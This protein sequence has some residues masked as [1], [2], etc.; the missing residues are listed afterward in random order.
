MLPRPLS[1]TP[2]IRGDQLKKVH[3]TITL[4]NRHITFLVPSQ[5]TIAAAAATLTAAA[6]QYNQSKSGSTQQPKYVPPAYSQNAEFASRAGNVNSNNTPSAEGIRPT[7]PYTARQTKQSTLQSAPNPN[8]SS[9]TYGRVTPAEIHRRANAAIFEGT[10]RI[11]VENQP[12]NTVSASM[13]TFIDPSEVFNPYHYELEKRRREETTETVTQA[14]HSANSSAQPTQHLLHGQNI[15]DQVTKPQ[16]AKPKKPRKPREKKPRQS[17]P[18]SKS[19]VQPPA[20]NQAPTVQTQ[21]SPSVDIANE[22]KSMIE[23]MREWKS[24]DPKLFQSLWDDMKK[25]S[26]AS[27][28]TLVQGQSTDAATSSKAADNPKPSQSSS[29]IQNK[30]V[31]PPSA[32]DIAQTSGPIKFSTPAVGS[33]STQSNQISLD[34]AVSSTSQTKSPAQPGLAQRAANTSAKITKANATPA[35]P[36]PPTPSVSSQNV[37]SQPLPPLS[38]RGGTIWPEDK[39]KALAEAA[40]TALNTDPANNGK[41]ITPNDIRQII[42]ENPSY[43]EL[44]RRL[45]NKGLVFQRSGFARHLLSS[46]PDLTSASSPQQGAP[47]ITSAPISLQSQSPVT[48]VMAREAS[49]P[50]KESP[51]IPSQTQRIAKSSKAS[52]SQKTGK[53]STVPEPPPGSKAAMARKRNFSEIVDLSQLSDYEDDD[54][55]LKQQRLSSP[56]P[57]V[58]GPPAPYSQPMSA[59]PLQFSTVYPPH[60]YPHPNIPGPA[61]HVLMH[62]SAVPPQHLGFG[63]QAQQKRSQNFVPVVKTLDQKEALKKAYYNPKTVARDILIAAGRHPTERPLNYHLA[64]IISRV[65]SLAATSQA[66]LSTFDW[67]SIDPGGPPM[68]RV[69]EVDIDNAPPKFP[70]RAKTAIPDSAR[71]RQGGQHATTALKSIV[72]PNDILAAQLS[73]SSGRHQRLS[74]SQAP[75]PVLSSRLSDVIQDS[76]STDPTTPQNRILRSISPQS[77]M[78]SGPSSGPRHRGRPPGS[79]NKQPPT[80]GP[81]VSINV[82][83]PAPEFPTFRCEWRACLV[84]L[85]NLAKLRKHVAQ[86]HKPLGDA[87]KHECWWRRCPY[88]QRDPVDDTLQ[89]KQF[90][91]KEEWIAHVEHE[92]LSPIARKLG[93][94]P[95]DKHVGKATTPNP[96]FSRFAYDTK[97]ASA[98]HPQIIEQQRKQFTSDRNGR[99]VTPISSIQSNKDLPTDPVTLP[100][101]EPGL[102]RTYIKTHTGDKGGGKHTAA[103]ELLRA[104]KW[105]KEHVG[106]GIDKGGATLVTPEVAATLIGDENIARIAEDNEGSDDDLV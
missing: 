37:L 61:N 12:S 10:S 8:S 40:A 63:R 27:A 62:S 58:P 57:E 102:F 26:V 56:V 105:R 90:D 14:Q 96:D 43:I 20:A 80:K 89:T 71:P 7:S 84:D 28:S 67:D 15:D 79:K 6:N 100:A 16:D 36:T 76:R 92:H 94:G 72:D 47:V 87:D 99:R 82:S 2:R 104:I 50:G 77:S 32:D 30:S 31:P 73:L 65:P 41:H 13:P 4:D 46:V 3:R 23:K 60:Q 103:E 70:L 64:T 75:K 59:A 83:E 85:H 38:S 91:T 21:S 74:G 97:L 81:I 19:K 78:T 42:S 35:P 5:G 51:Q 29:A 55:V 101:E 34:D 106:P 68:P 98:K 53:K 52:V 54:P 93:D 39:R 48:S 33:R 45:E 24:K 95:S 25:G 22:M 9:E 49:V 1:L 44:C 17:E 11:P 69:E 18:G 66:D 88:I 86:V